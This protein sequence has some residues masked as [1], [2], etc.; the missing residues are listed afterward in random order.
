LI[1][2]QQVLQTDPN[3]SGLFIFVRV[4]EF[5]QAKLTNWLKSAKGA[6]LPFI[7]NSLII[8]AYQD[9]F[10]PP[11]VWPLSCYFE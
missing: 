6:I 3:K 9:S 4:A 1:K 8:N 7:H 10:S 5:S 11:K 2:R